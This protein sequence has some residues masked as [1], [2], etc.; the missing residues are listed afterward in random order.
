M[1]AS[2]LPKLKLSFLV[3]DEEVYPFSEPGQI[4]IISSSL[5]SSD[6]AINQVAAEMIIG[7]ARDF[8]FLLKRDLKHTISMQ[9]KLFQEEGIVINDPRYAALFNDNVKGMGVAVP[10]A[11]VE[12]VGLAHLKKSEV[13][14]DEIKRGELQIGEPCIIVNPFAFLMWQNGIKEPIELNMEISGFHAKGKGG[15]LTTAAFRFPHMY[16]DMVS[17]FEGRRRNELKV[18]IVGPG[19]QKPDGKLGFCSQFVELKAL[20]PKAHFL[21]LDN[22]TEALAYLEKQFK[23]VK[24]AAYDPLTLRMLTFD[25]LKTNVLLAPEKFQPMLAEMKNELAACAKFPSNAKE[26]LQG[27]GEIK[28]MMLEVNPDYIELREFDI[29]TSEFKGD[30]KFDVM[31][32][33]MSICLALSEGDPQ[34]FKKIML[35]YVERLNKEGSLYIDS[36]LMHQILIPALGCDNP[37]EVAALLSEEAGVKFSLDRVGLE[38]YLPE[39][40]GDIGSLPNPDLFS[41]RNDDRGIV[42]ITTHSVFVLT[43][44]LQKK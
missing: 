12:E 7:I 32:A 1:S 11:L 36:G 19:L 31:V 15:G 20:F 25:Q 2:V 34:D 5:E 6:S 41:A 37:E 9:I 22:D 29:N 17:R 23:G 40:A 35:K 21:L 44:T 3:P 10:T 27:F 24:A 38:T 18:C 13:D 42:S 26:M 4:P 43:S 28:Q 14:K 16:L 33:T 8:A 30:E 39:T